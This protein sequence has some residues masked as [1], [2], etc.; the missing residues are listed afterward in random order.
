MDRRET[1]EREDRLGLGPR[2]GL[3]PEQQALERTRTIELQGLELDP[4][5]EARIAE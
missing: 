3:P 4:A 5:T 1:M 2:A